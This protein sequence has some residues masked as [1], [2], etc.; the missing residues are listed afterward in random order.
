[1][2]LGA[3]I[4][5]ATA[6]NGTFTLI[7]CDDDDGPGLNPTICRSGSSAGC[8]GVDPGVTCTYNAALTPGQTIY[9]RVWRYNNGSP[10]NTP[11]QICVIECSSSSSGCGAASYASQSCPCPPPAGGSWCGAGC[12]SAG[13]TSDDVY[14]PSWISLPFNFYFAGS[15]YTQLLIGANGLVVFPPSGFTPGDYDG[16]GWGG[17]AND[18][19]SIQFQQDINPA[20]GGTIC[21]RTVGT[22]PNRCFVVQYCNVPL[23]GSA[24][25]GLTFTGEL[26]LCENNVIQI[27]INNK[28]TCSGW[29]GG[30]CLIGLVGSSSGDI[31]ALHNAQPCPSLTNTCW[32]FTPSSSCA[33][34]GSPCSPLAVTLEAFEG[35]VVGDKVQVVW[36]SAVEEGVRRWWVERSADLRSWERIGDLPAQGRPSRYVLYDDKYPRG[37]SSLYYRLWAEEEAGERSFGP[38]EVVLTERRPIRPERFDLRGEEGLPIRL[39]TGEEVVVTVYD[40]QGR[41]T[42]EERYSGPGRVEV[43]AVFFSRGVNIVHIAV[44]GGESAAYRVLRW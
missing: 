24:C 16:W 36:E 32:A 10:G 5:S 8:T 29:N 22:A 13:I 7:E 14:S 38:I 20:L 26:Y 12:T 41:R 19:Y 35:V 17:Y 27:N 42:F 34:S 40:M 37:Y 28:P 1:M 11:F 39:G 4:Y 15:T 30:G 9:V 43:P 21:Y 33:T 31:N 18:L 25:T 44:V 3:A 2:D 23:F 6:C